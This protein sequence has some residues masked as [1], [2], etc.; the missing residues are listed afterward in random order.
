[1]IVRSLLLAV[2]IWSAGCILAE[3]LTG[4]ILFPG[5]SRKNAF[6][7]QRFHVHHHPKW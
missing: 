5:E 1:M 2:D 3:M 6:W 7:F 4:K